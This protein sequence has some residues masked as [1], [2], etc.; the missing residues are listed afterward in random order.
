MAQIEKSG[1]REMLTSRNFFEGIC[2]ESQGFASD[3]SRAHRAVLSFVS[4]VSPRVEEVR[5]LFADRPRL[6]R[7]PGRRVSQSSVGQVCH[8]ELPLR[9][10]VEE[11]VEGARRLSIVR[12]L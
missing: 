8:P 6:A 5:T 10:N 9:K 2:T 4:G 11:S 3:S 7:R 1:D 12:P